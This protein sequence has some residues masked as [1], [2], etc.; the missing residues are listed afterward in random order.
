MPVPSPN[1]GEGSQA[2]ISRCIK[3]LHHSD[4]DRP[5]DQ[6]QGMCYTTLRK[7]RGKKT[8]LAEGIKMPNIKLALFDDKKNFEKQDAKTWRKQILAFGVWRHPENRETEFE[9]TSEV[10]DQIIKNFKEGVPVEA[11][12]VL[13][14]TDNPKAK[15]GGVKEF[16]KTEKGLDAV[17]T[18]DDDEMNANIESSDK[19]PGVSCWLDLAYKDKKTDQDVGAVVKH[20]ALVNHPY[21]EGLSGF[22]NVSLSDK[23][24]KYTPLIM[25]EEKS[26]GG[27]N[28]PE[29]TKE[30]AIKFLKDK[31]KVDVAT[32]LS[33]SE[34]LKVLSDKID[35]GEL[36]SKE[37][38]GK[39]LSAELMKQL[40]DELKL[41]DGNGDDKK[42][43]V[44]VKSMIEKF[45]ALSATQKTTQDEVKTINAAL[46]DMRAEAAVGS[47]LKDGFAFPKEKVT[48]EKLYHSDVKLFEEMAKTRREGNKYVK[49]G[50]EGVEEI[51]A[52][53]A[54][55][56]EDKKEIDRQVKAAEDE[57]LIPAKAVAT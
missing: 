43:E 29:I 17:L 54:E 12:V 41:G 16:I 21:I 10:A 39:V 8:L 33:D 23:E 22:Q 11:P 38:K 2:F 25:S 37:D 47:L 6:I 27:I 15:V 14:H 50:E 36:V 34:E 19:A 1:E 49:L 24:E 5:D 35:K 30:I 45:T 31:A 57:G 13:T 26:D 48:L 40:Q 7:A 55:E 32:L 20:V 42:A 4:P 52:K 51:E 28:M 46:T 3:A 18:V 53:E 44:L 56:V 9:I